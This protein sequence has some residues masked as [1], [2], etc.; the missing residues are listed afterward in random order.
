MTNAAYDILPMLHMTYY[1]SVL[2]TIGGR[3]TPYIYFA[4]STHVKGKPHV[5]LFTVGT[6]SYEKITDCP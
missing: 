2:C 3:S 5:T 6:P 4:V 1:M